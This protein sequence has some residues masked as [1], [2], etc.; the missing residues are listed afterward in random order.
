MEGFV[1]HALRA[2]TNI[3]IATI[4]DNLN[5]NIVCI[6]ARCSI[7]NEYVGHCK[8]TGFHAI[9]SS[10]MWRVLDLQEAS[11]R[12]SLRGLD[13]AAADGVDDFKDLL[14]GDLHGTTLSHP[15]IF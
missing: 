12:K 5:L 7:I 8:E 1:A 15:T 4:L 14:K 10:T 6:V 3:L 2:S 9:S 13:N 11:Q